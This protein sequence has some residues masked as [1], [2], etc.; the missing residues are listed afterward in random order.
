MHIYVFGA[1][2]THGAPSPGTGPPERVAPLMNQLFAPQ[3]ADYANEV[4]LRARELEGLRASIGD[5]P[6]E[7]W[8]T[9]KWTAIQALRTPEAKETERTLFGRIAFY[10][11]RLFLEVSWTWTED[12]YHRIFLDQVVARDEP[13]GM[14]SFNYDTFLD[15]AVQ[16]VR[17]ADLTTLSGYHRANLVKPH[18]SINWIVPRRPS[19]P[20]IEPGREGSPDYAWRFAFASGRMFNGTPI[21]SWDEVLVIPPGHRALLP[22][23][24]AEGVFRWVY[25]SYFY[26]LV[27]LP[28]TTKLYDFAPLLPGDMI[29]QAQGLLRQAED[30]YVIGYRGRDEIFGTML[31]A[32][33]EGARLHVI[34]RGSAQETAD[35]ILGR[36]PQMRLAKVHTG[37]FR[38]F[39][40]VGSP[41]K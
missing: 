15:Q 30:V 8:L 34:G 12:D 13:F 3:Y 26:P 33:P 29:G 40:E 25:F 2:A 22:S 10:V 28:L 1:G 20:L 6:V 41:A 39:V 17:G 35:R 19:D 36:C 18:G 32:V 9:T 27:M 24:F 37:G 23:P 11:W 31:D 21:S 4:T 5:A 7:D 14:I 38:G 16:R